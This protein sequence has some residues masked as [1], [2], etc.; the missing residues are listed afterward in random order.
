MI[1]FW[2]TSL[3]DC[4]VKDLVTLLESTIPREMV[5]EKP[6]TSPGKHDAVT[7]ATILDVNFMVE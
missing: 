6:D 1:I 3:T 7:K 4:F 5:V 2:L